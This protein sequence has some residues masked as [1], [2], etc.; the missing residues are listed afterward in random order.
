MKKPAF[1]KSIKL[2]NPVPNTGGK[3]M[4]TKINNPSKV[5]A[6]DKTFGGAS[7][8]KVKPATTKAPAKGAFNARKYEGM[9]RKV[10]G[11][12]KAREEDMGKI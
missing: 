9:R 11:M 1:K 4:G 5:G 2:T 6:K 12:G 8:A 10:F 7:K 3:A